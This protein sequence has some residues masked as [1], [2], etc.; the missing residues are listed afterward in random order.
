M[1]TYFGLSKADAIANLTLAVKIYGAEYTR[2]IQ[3]RH[4]DRERAMMLRKAYK[5][6]EGALNFVKAQKD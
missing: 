6:A 1:K 2:E 4:P 3:H 5:H